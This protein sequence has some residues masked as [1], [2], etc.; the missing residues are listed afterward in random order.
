MSPRR[1][2]WLLGTIAA[3]ALGTFAVVM[4]GGNP[5]HADGPAGKNLQV[6]PKDI[7]KDT[8]KKQMKEMS[9]S[10]GKKCDGCHDVDAFDKDTEKKTIAREM[11]K[12]TS[13]INAQ[14][15]K[16][17]A[18]TKVTCATCHAGKEKPDE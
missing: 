9:K 13:A 11:M 10:V 7:D 8:L 6:L 2:H 15:E 18:K 4:L 12:M 3:L 1:S 17:G 16:D 14:L 5:A